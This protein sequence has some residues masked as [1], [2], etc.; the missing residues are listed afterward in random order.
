M[1]L[2]E[3]RATGPGQ[4]LPCPDKRNDNSVRSR[5]GDLF[6]CDA[7][8]EFRFPSTGSRSQ[9]DDSQLVINE[10]LSYVVHY[11]DRV[12]VEQ[13]RKVLVSFYSAT[14]I[15]GAKK[16]MT[17]CYASVLEGCA[18]KAER[19]KS[20]AR[21]VHEA[22]VD[23]IIG[24]LDY[25]DQRN[26]L[27]VTFVAVNLERLPR[28]GPEDLNICT[29]ADNQVSLSAH[30]EDLHTHTT[31]AVS[32]IEV[33]VNDAFLRLQSLCLEVSENVAK[34][35]PTPPVVTDA[36]RSNAGRGSDNVDRTRNVM[37]FGIDESRDSGWRDT[38]SQAINI[39]AGRDILIEDAFRIG[40]ATGS[41]KRPVLVKL[42]SAW[43][44]RAVVSGSW[45]LAS[46]AGFEKIFIKAD[47]PPEVRNRKT[48]DR[49]KRKAI[50]EGKEV[51][52]VD[53]ILNID[54]VNVFSLERG[55][56]RN[57]NA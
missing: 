24:I 2:C 42:K 41:G 14:E 23:D 29:I 26:A 43:D 47:E 30:I 37:V 39:A 34:K 12:A 7:C 25:I 53:G 21:S 17:T 36:Q 28:Y 33:S 40:R 9:P 16:L 22:E 44:R 13:L 46:S 38:V 5:Q 27:S 48:M 20:S 6:L 52:V 32:R 54:H 49:L 56:I 50:S 19:R 10:L 4:V 15:N 55:F 8:T 31:A 51:A 1:P 57:H 11:R 18:L 35:L 45:K 3:G